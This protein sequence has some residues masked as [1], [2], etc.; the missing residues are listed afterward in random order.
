ML[1][2]DSHPMAGSRREDVGDLVD[3][4]C[5]LAAGAVQE[6]PQS[7]GDRL[8]SHHVAQRSKRQRVA[9]TVDKRG[10]E[11]AQQ[12][13]AVVHGDSA[14]GTEIIRGEQV[15][16]G[17]SLKVAIHIA[18]QRGR[19][20]APRQGESRA[21]IGHHQPP[22]RPGRNGGGCLVPQRTNRPM[23]RLRLA[24]QRAAAEVVEK[25]IQHMVIDVAGSD[26][27]EAAVPGEPRKAEPGA[28][29]V[30]VAEQVSPLGCQGGTGAGRH[31]CQAGMLQGGPDQAER[32]PPAPWGETRHCGCEVFQPRAE[33]CRIGRQIVHGPSQGLGDG[34]Q[35]RDEVVAT[36]MRERFIN[37][38]TVAQSG[39]RRLL[40]GVT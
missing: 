2:V 11:A 10:N 7:V 23:D 40:G 9:A 15:R 34:A 14:Q 31:T 37:G 24:D 5:F 38:D 32:I 28:P 35:G 39:E 13:R 3:I 27:A 8:D 6:K 21:P 12:L 33:V 4:R 16:A 20:C 1:G 29:I 36:S 22:I 26:A 30:E 25:D 18:F 17:E 19:I